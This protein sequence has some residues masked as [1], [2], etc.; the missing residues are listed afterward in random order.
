MVPTAADT[1][2]T[3]GH[4]PGA[5]CLF[6]A[7]WERARRHEQH[8]VGLA[9]LRQPRGRHRDAQVGAFHWPLFGTGGDQ[10]EAGLRQQQAEAALV[11]GVD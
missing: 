2:Q 10:A 11:E 1:D 6:P 8:S 3:S 7:P 9:G 4:L 5:S